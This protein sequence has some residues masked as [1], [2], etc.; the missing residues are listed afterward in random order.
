M[1]TIAAGFAIAGTAIGVSG[2]TP[3]YADGHRIRRPQL[4]AAGVPL[5]V[6]VL[7]VLALVVEWMLR[8]TS[9]GR[10]MYLVGENRPAARAAGLPVGRT[11]TVAWLGFGRP[12][13]GDTGVFPAA[14][15]TSANVTLGGT[16]T[17]DAIAAVLVGG[18]AIAGG[19]GSALRTLA[20]AVLIAVIVGHAAAARLLHR[21]PDPGQGTARPRRRRPRPPAVD[22]RARDDPR[23]DRADPSVLMPLTASLSLV[24]SPSRCTPMRTDSTTRDRSTSTTRSRASPSSV[25][26]R[27]RSG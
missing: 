6:Y 9:V 10:Q 25:C 21:C 13:R 22:A 27:S 24:R 5:S 1:L 7:L 26:W 14:F 4:D 23:V 18:T 3:V 17:L 12:V 20:G 15:N 8:R 2:G 16:L 11:T 19:R